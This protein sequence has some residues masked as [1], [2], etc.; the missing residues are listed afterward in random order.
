MTRLLTT[1]FLVLALCL[2]A[3]AV[4]AQPVLATPSIAFPHGQAADFAEAESEEEGEEVEGEEV[5]EE[6]GCEEPEEACE[7]SAD[8]SG[9][10]S[11]AGSCPLRSA[12]GH[13]STR[14]N[15][16]KVT[17]GYTTYRPVDA[18]I[19]IRQGSTDV[20]TFE[21]H[22]ERSGVLRF[23][24]KVGKKQGKRVIVQID[25]TERAGCPSRRLVLFRP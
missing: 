7:E 2:L 12:Q 8:E 4:A 19:Q 16:L 11:S 24:E 21:R 5:E 14:R 10:A 20:G 13:A 23:T 1:A 15:K 18:T 6:V 17:V 9:D 3:V 25:P 22:L